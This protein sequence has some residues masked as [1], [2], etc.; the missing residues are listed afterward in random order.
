MY[1]QGYTRER[2]LQDLLRVSHKLSL[3]AFVFRPIDSQLKQQ[4]IEDLS[5][6]KEELLKQGYTNDACAITPISSALAILQSI[7]DPD[8]LPFITAVDVVQLVLRAVKSLSSSPSSLPVPNRHLPPELLQHIFT[9]LLAEESPAE[10]QQAILSL[11]RTSVSWRRIVLERPFVYIDSLS[12][13]DKF[14]KYRKELERSGS[15]QWHQ[16]WEEVHID[17]SRDDLHDSVVGALCSSTFSIGDRSSWYTGKLILNL[18]V[19]YG[20]PL[21]HDAL[22][23]LSG[24]T[25]EWRDSTVRLPGSEVDHYSNAGNL[26]YPG[27]IGLKQNREYFVGR[28]EEPVLL[29]TSSTYQISRDEYEA[30]ECL[31]ESEKEE[32]QIIS[33]VPIL[34]NYTVFAAPWLPFELSDFLFGITGNA[35][36]KE[37][38]WSPLRH[39]ELSFELDAR[40]PRRAIQ[41]IKTFFSIISTAIERLAFRIR[42]SSIHPSLHDERRFTE[43]L[44]ASLCSCTRL[45]HLEIGGF[46]FNHD[47]VSGLSNLPLSTLVLLPSQNIN[48]TSEVVSLLDQTSVLRASLELLQ[49]DQSLVDDQ[50]WVTITALGH[51]HGVQV[52]KEN[53][54]KEKE[55]LK[56]LISQA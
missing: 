21:S 45:R 39:L 11:S 12:K 48:S 27:W 35:E 44:V 26:L 22:N 32:D 50:S 31:K 3:E 29:D 43:H 6:I 30:R 46:G 2:A 20:T 41:E 7:L 49:L 5:G 13:L 55:L 47:L 34:T 4:A 54:E 10:R 33:N 1:W 8:P 9:F 19:I 36:S 24:F 15:P 18:A 52:E 42:L 51:Q 25:E 38:C 53:R 16:P 14:A 56:E 17:L 37:D 23:D 28:S 40:N